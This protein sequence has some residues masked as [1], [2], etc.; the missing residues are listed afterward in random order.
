MTD[1]PIEKF[2]KIKIGEQ[3]NASDGEVYKKTGEL[4][5][6]DAYGFEHYIDPLFDKKIG[7]VLKPQT[8]PDVDVSAKVVKD[9]PLA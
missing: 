3:F 1:F 9:E 5:F 8:K 6:T 2:N 4:T 7:E